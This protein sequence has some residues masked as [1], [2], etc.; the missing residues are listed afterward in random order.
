MAADLDRGVHGSRAGHPALG[1]RS[2]RTRR[3]RSTTS[4]AA[5]NIPMNILLP[6]LGIMLVTSEW[7]QRTAMVTFT[8]E[9]SRDRLIG[10][11][12]RRH[13]GRGPR[14]GGGRAGP[15]RSSPTGS[16]A[17]SRTTRVTWDWVP[18]LIFLLPAHCYRMATGF[19]FG[20]LLLNTAAAIV[21]FFVYSFVL[22]RLFELGSNLMGWFERPPA[23]DRLQQRAVAVIEAD[24]SRR[25][26]G[27]A[28][29]VR[30][31]LAGRCRWG[32]AS[33]GCCAPR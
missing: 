14:R 22:P 7:S 17:R 26:V 27:P 15:A 23:V 19:A 28:G 10:G 6:V 3:C 32:S 1:G 11:E 12:V 31:D 21:V 2:P 25:G 5:P 18:F 9:P 13:A 33:G 8:L 29:D 16:T 30:P 4:P 20:A 24:L